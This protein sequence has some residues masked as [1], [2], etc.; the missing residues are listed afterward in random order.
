MDSIRRHTLMRET[1]LRKALDYHCV[2]ET[3]HRT[4]DNFCSRVIRSIVALG[5]SA[6]RV[7]TG[8]RVFSKPYDTASETERVWAGSRKRSA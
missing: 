6:G 2:W 8:F 4:T 1:L 5:Q 7:S 3:V